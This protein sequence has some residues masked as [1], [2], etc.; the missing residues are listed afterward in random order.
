MFVKMHQ[1][2]KKNQLKHFHKHETLVK[3]TQW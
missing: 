3:V 1:L 2:I